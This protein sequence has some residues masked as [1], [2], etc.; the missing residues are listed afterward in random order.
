[1]ELI[2]N[3]RSRHVADR[4]SLATL[5]AE[6]TDDTRGLAVAVDGTVVR[7]ADW[8]DRTLHEGARVEIVGASQ[9]G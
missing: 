5:L 7:R 8:E 6:V 9:G 4:I 1:M 2:C 3:G